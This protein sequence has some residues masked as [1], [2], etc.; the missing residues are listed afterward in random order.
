VQLK[1]SQEGVSFREFHNI[2][3]KKLKVIYKICLKYWKVLRNPVRKCNE[4]N[5][6]LNYLVQLIDSNNTH[7]TGYI[8]YRN[9]LLN[10]VK[11][12]VFRDKLCN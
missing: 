3:F 7:V 2:S 9:E 11:C 10:S 1:V 4:L 12:W 5:I 8:N 6:Y